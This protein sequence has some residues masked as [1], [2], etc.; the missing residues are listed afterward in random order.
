MIIFTVETTTFD[1]FLLC[2]FT[3]TLVQIFYVF[4]AWTN[5]IERL[6]QKVL[7]LPLTSKMLA[8]WLRKKTPES[9]IWPSTRHCLPTI[10]GISCHWKR[11]LLFVGE[12]L[13]QCWNAKSTQKW[14]CN[15]QSKFQCFQTNFRA[16]SLWNRGLVISYSSA[17]LCSA[18]FSHCII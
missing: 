5:V 18:L 15:Q 1:F 17:L 4:G 12:N 16:A 7:Y 6:P 10:P 3:P 2:S 14:K 11:K 9:Q 13:I 8:Y